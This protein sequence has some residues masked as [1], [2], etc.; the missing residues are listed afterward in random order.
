MIQWYLSGDY[1]RFEEL[2]ESM[3]MASDPGLRKELEK[4]LVYDRNARF[5]QRIAEKIRENPEKNFFFAIG[6]GH[7]GGDRSIK[8][9]LEKEG[10][11]I[12]G[13]N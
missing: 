5:A 1:M 12:R 10:I 6:M 11:G 3:P 9:L 8:A 7:L 13:R 4:Q 2:L